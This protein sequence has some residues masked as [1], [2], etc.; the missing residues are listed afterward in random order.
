MGASPRWDKVGDTSFQ[1]V[2]SNETSPDFRNIDEQMLLKGKSSHR[3]NI[4]FRTLSGPHSE[5][6]EDVNPK[7]GE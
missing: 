3:E 5:F 1:S 6:V 2:S 7:T 4:E